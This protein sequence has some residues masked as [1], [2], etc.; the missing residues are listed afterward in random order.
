MNLYFFKKI[1]KLSW[2][3]LLE[4]FRRAHDEISPSC[5]FLYHHLWSRRERASLLVHDV[6]VLE[7][8]QPTLLKSKDGYCCR[9][10]INKTTHLKQVQFINNS[11]VEMEKSWSTESL[12]CFIKLG[13]FTLGKG[14][15]GTNIVS[16]L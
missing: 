6:I 3:N 8:A 7:R 12:V 1:W 5:W 14:L 16:V 9:W 11:S 13:Q 4:L 15:S 10:Y 2:T